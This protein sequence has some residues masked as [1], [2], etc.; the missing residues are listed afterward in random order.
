MTALFFLNREVHRYCEVGFVAVFTIHF[1][2]C[3]AIE[4]LDGGGY[5]FRRTKPVFRIMMVDDGKSHFGDRHGDGKHGVEA[6]RMCFFVFLPQVS[7][8]EVVNALLSLTLILGT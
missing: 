1:D 6:L 8:N 5:I 3:D 4:S 2:L 7:Q